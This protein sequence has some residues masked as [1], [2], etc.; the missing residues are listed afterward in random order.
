MVIPQNNYRF[1]VTFL[2]QLSLM[3]IFTFYSADAGR[4]ARGSNSNS[5]VE[6]SSDQQYGGKYDEQVKVSDLKGGMRY[7]VL[8]K[9]FQDKSNYSY[10]YWNYGRA[11]SKVTRAWKELLVDALFH[12][13]SFLVIS[14]E[15][16]RGDARKEQEMQDSDWSKHNSKKAPKGRI[17]GADLLVYGAV[18]SIIEDKSSMGGALLG[19]LGV[20]TGKSTIKLHIRIVDATSGTT[21]ASKEIEGSSRSW[22][23]KARPMKKVGLGFSSNP[24]LEKATADALKKAADYC[25]RQLDYVTW[26]AKVV[27]SNGG[28]IIIN[29]GEREGVKVGQIFEVGTIEKLYDEDNGELLDFF[30]EKVANL[31]VVKVSN[32]VAYCRKTSTGSVDI[33]KSMGVWLP[34]S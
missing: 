30:K 15:E 25:A 32:K 28:K 22:G 23:I 18:T 21:V 26:M 19:K 33:E 34:E 14:D 1:I 24:D 2:T 16:D 8:V 31:E 17:S 13:G 4:P 6:T 20:K 3:L 12:Q 5:N 29:R 9:S 11:S 7:S 27:K 10:P